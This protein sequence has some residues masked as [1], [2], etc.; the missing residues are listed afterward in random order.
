MKKLLSL[1]TFSAAASSVLAG[2]D[3]LGPQAKA[4]LQTHCAGCHGGG[5][6]SKGGFGFVLDRDRLISRLLVAPGQASQS[7]LLLARAARRDAA[8]IEQNPAQ[9]G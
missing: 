3:G 4:I 1:L 8:E 9:R 2:S 5:A 7:D 6:A